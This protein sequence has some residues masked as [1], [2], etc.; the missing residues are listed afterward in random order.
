MKDY[1]SVGEVCKMKDI[2]VGSLRYYEELGLL[3]PV[4][5]NP[6]SGYRYYSHHQMLQLDLILTCIDLDI[7]L[8]E[9]KKHF[10]QDGWIDFGSIQKMG[11]EIAEKKIKKIQNHMEMFG[12]WTKH[13]EETKK[14]MEHQW[15]GEN[16]VKQEK[17][18]FLYGEKYP[19]DYFLFGEY[20]KIR[21]KLLKELAL[22]D[23]KYC[24]EEGLL[25]RIERGKVSFY[26]FCQ[27][28]KSVKNRTKILSSG[29]YTSGIARNSGDM[30]EK[31]EQMGEESKEVVARFIFNEDFNHN[32]Q[33]FE[34]QKQCLGGGSEKE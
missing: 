15:L 4:Y 13:M 11:E 34:V 30:I 19:F 31:M 7:P 21:S 26:V 28:N 20:E 5:V 6:S 14:L 3:L 29:K 1:F 32:E 22:I 12:Y 25:R 18:R 17:K 23:V 9:V 2:S 24:Y 33:Y 8:K 10:K 27:V 16:Y